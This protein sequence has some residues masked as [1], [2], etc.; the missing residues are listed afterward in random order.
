MLFNEFNEIESS[1]SSSKSSNSLVTALTTH[2][3]VEE[4]KNRTTEVTEYFIIGEDFD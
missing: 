3:V 1:S 4:A 2:Q